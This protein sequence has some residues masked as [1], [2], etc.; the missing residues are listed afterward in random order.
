ML[1]G[2]ACLTP[3]FPCFLLLCVSCW[4]YWLVILRSEWGSSSLK[5]A[6][7][8]GVSLYFWELVCDVSKNS[9][10]WSCLCPNLNNSGFKF[11]QRG[12]LM[13]FLP[14][15]I[16]Q[17]HLDFFPRKQCK[18]IC[19]LPL[20]LAFFFFLTIPRGSILFLLYENLP[21]IVGATLKY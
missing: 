6:V 3:L 20:K 15:N 11:G 8:N 17:L 14:F 19:F 13:S 9:T 16:A 2:V 4:S 10:L 1:S 21:V 5:I 12:I 7:L 18:N